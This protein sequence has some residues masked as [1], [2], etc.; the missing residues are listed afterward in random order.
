MDFTA[1]L[2]WAEEAKDLP[3][4]AV[5]AEFC[6]RQNMPVGAALLQDLGTYASKVAHRG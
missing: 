1:R 6:T 4:G 2:I 5:W 3:F